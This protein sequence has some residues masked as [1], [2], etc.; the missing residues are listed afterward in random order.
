VPNLI[1][2][3]RC[4]GILLFAAIISTHLDPLQGFTYRIVTDPEYKEED[5]EQ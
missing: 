5:Y 4:L 1:T 2:K 3:P